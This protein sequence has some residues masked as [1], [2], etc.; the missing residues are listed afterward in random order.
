MLLH[1]SHK[2]EN[3]RA[4]A[5]RISTFAFA[6]VMG[7]GAGACGLSGAPP[8]TDQLG[9][10]PNGG[11]LPPG[12]GGGGGGGGGMMTPPD[13]GGGGG[14]KSPYSAFYNVESVAEDGAFL[15]IRTRNLPDHGSPFYPETDPKYEAYTGTNPS[16]STKINLMGQISDPDI[17]AQDL[18]FRIPRTPTPAA[19]PVP[20]GLGAIGVAINGVVIFNQYNGARAL[21]DTL[22]FN[23]FDQYNG[24]PTPAPGQ[25]YHYHV[26]P[27]WLTQ[28]YGSSALVGF[29]LDGYPIYGPVENG[30]R[31]RSADLDRLHGHAHATP[32]YPGGI[33]HYHFTDDAPWLNGDGY[34]GVPGTVSR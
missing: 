8:A 31:L 18:T 4:R 29:L 15:V 20:T 26:E 7:A 3:C 21:L 23:N 6:L 19:R 28:K 32:E 33:Y 1:S 10:A 5:A 14:A 17:R 27:L 30:A 2:R 24:H 9:P 11:G 13:G 16:F 22:E 12:G 34:H 25:Q